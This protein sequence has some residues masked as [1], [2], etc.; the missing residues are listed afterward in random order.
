[1]TL[2]VDRTGE[3][4]ARAAATHALVI[5][6]SFYQHLPEKGELPAAG[7]VTLGLIQA[8]TPATSAFAFA[9]W[10]RDHYRN[11]SAPLATIRL[12]LSPAASET[13]PPA[14]PEL[15]EAA[16]QVDRALT[17]AVRT[18]LF[19]WQAA[20]RGNPKSVAMFYVSG[21]GVQISRDDSI[22][23]L[24][25]FA[26]DPYVLDYSI[27]VGRVF[28]GMAGD[29]YAQ[30][31]F[32]FVDACRVRPE[33][34]NR[35]KD[36]GRGLG[37]PEEWD[38]ADRRA[39][40]IIFS[41]SPDT[42]AFGR[43]GQGTL[44]SQALITSL[45]GLAVESFPDDQGGEWYVSAS[46]LQQALE[47]LVAK[48]SEPYGEIQT[49][50]PGGQ[51]RSATFHHLSAVPIVP[52]AIQIDPD[53]AARVVR[54]NI[55]DAEHAQILCNI[56]TFVP[57]PVIQDLPA[58]ACSLDVQIIPPTPPYIAK[59]SLAK[60]VRPRMGDGNAWNVKVRG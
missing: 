45:E 21:H 8:E 43:P 14:N 5:G 57:N 56:P 42:P 24:E 39:A 50:V 31:Q 48:L 12:L 55:W 59:L 34:F 11:P 6:T 33:E 10:L 17:P 15:A 27:D 44:F 37:L 4:P 60:Y 52:V 53:Q 38:G 18:E 46:S 3:L 26:Q 30:T 40:P 19:A 51:P 9:M 35:Y 47:A 23:L 7:V 16:G 36:L 28:R 58:G 32:Y 54:A 13:N 2:W 29:A 25:D 22:V 20:C 1:V 41:A 49:V